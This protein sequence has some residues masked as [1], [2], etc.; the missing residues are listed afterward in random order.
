MNQPPPL[1]EE[2]ARQEAGHM[3]RYW[4]EHLYDDVQ[5]PAERDRRVAQYNATETGRVY[6]IKLTRY[7]YGLFAAQGVE[8][9]EVV[10][11][12]VGFEVRDVVADQLPD[13]YDKV[14]P[15][16]RAGFSRVGN[17][18]PRDHPLN[19]P[20][21][22]N[23]PGFMGTRQ[24][25][26]FKVQPN[27]KLIAVGDRVLMVATTRILPG[28]EVLLHYGYEYWKDRDYYPTARLERD[29]RQAS[30][31]RI[32][33]RVDRDHGLDLCVGCALAPA[34]GACPCALVRVCGQT[35]L[36]T[37]W[38]SGHALVCP[39]GGGGRRN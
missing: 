19:Y 11:E 15:S 39:L 16:A 18:Q 33:N 22:A 12:Y 34:R 23:D 5:D 3:M 10:G 30:K 13:E 8:D 28:G 24:T 4:R 17:V 6:P 7:G 36:A 38:N 32:G 2:Q 35:C 37:V 14:I 21:Y 26:F 29:A 1:S 27:V 31:R 20:A 9:G 25:G